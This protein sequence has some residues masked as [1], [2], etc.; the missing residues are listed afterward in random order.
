MSNI[1][2]LW[3][4]YLVSLGITKRAAANMI[5]EQLQNEL[6]VDGGNID[7]LWFRYLRNEGY[8]GSRQDMLQKYLKE[9]E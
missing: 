6:G 3:V 4:E 2:D 5:S 8:T 7:D 9:I 1:D